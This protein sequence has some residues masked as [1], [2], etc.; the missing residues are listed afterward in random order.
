[1]L[2]QLTVTKTRIKTF[3]HN[4]LDVKN[5]FI[6]CSE[7]HVAAIKVFT[8]EVFHSSLSSSVGCNSVTTLQKAN[9]SRTLVT[10]TFV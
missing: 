8:D 7:V 3:I 2:L 4:F 9:M 1:M 10:C 6:R 5:T